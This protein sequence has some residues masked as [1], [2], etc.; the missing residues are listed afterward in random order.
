MKH[1]FFMVKTGLVDREYKRALQKGSRVNLISQIMNRRAEVFTRKPEIKYLIANRL[2]W[3]DSASKMKKN[4]V[5]IE[6]FGQAV[7]RAGF[8][9]VVLM[10]MG[11]SSLCPELFKL[12]SNKHRT[13]KSF[14]VIDA[15]DPRAVKDLMRKIEIKKTL[16]IVASK[17]GG[18]VETRSHEAFFIDRLKKAGVSDFGRHLVAITDKGSSLEKFARKNKYRKVFLN[19]ADIGGR[20]SALSY[21]GLVPGFFAG[22]NLKKLTDNAIMMEDLLRKRK[23]ETNP[24]LVLGVLM[25]VASKAGIN[26]LTFVASKKTA[27]LIPWIEQLVAESTGKQRK[28]VIPIENEPPGKV[29]AYG[30]DRLFVLMR[31]AGE[32]EVLPLKTRRE[33]AGKKFPMVEIVMN[34]HD[35]LG[36]QF[37]LWEAA[38]AAAGYYLNINPFDEPNVTES[39]NNTRSILDAY[40][41]MG[42]LPYQATLADWEGMSLIAVEGTR[43]T[44]AEIANMEKI[45]KK[46]FSGLKAGEYF[47]LLNYFKADKS[48]EKV[49][50]KI[51]RTIRDNKKVATLRGYGPRFLHSVGQLYK[52]GPAIGRFVVFTRA[53]YDRLE[54]PGQPFDFGKL[55][56]AQAIGDSR[57]LVR[58]KLPLLVITLRGNPAGELEKFHA[59]LKKILK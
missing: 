9:H 32:K 29:S 30:H 23:G 12:V 27:P 52:G 58:R 59:L 26:K 6:K 7:I 37:L 14:D 57:A 41:R 21:F 4:I 10:G 39:K 50:E 24:A 28:G 18:T 48:T 16:F 55:I 13:L 31:M 17:S 1:G 40:Q 35:D 34:T 53:E 3:V 33:L 46:Y 47:A 15:T 44:M 42:Q 43:Y 22:V 36:G 51:R 8:R 2:G 45:L 54:I 38:T 49:L 19:P 25:A 56:T 20:Y 11:G 5:A